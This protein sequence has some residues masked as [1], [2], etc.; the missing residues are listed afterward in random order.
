MQIDAPVQ[1]SRPQ[2]EAE[3]RASSAV[4]DE[5]NWVANASLIWDHRHTLLSTAALVFVLSIAVVLLLPKEYES[6]ARI[7]PPE[8]GSNSAAMLAALVGRGSPVGSAS[9]IAGLAGSLLGVKNNGALFIALL[10]SGTI[11]GH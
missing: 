7:M 3:H 4:S 6:S 9:G 10:H 8:S 5:A 2:M 11:S 1:L